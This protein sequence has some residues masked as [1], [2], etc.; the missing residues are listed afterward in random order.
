V[1]LSQLEVDCLDL[2]GD[3]QILITGPFFPA[4]DP[5]SVR[6]ACAVPP[7][8]VIDSAARLVAVDRSLDQFLHGSLT[9]G[10]PS[11]ILLTHFAGSE[12]FRDKLAAIVTGVV[13]LPARVVVTGILFP[14]SYGSVAIVIDVPE[15]WNPPHR[16]SLLAGFGPQGRDSVAQAI[17]DALLPAVA[18]VADR[19]CPEATGETVLPYFNLTYVATTTH[20]LPGR[21][22][23]PDELRY[24][25]YPRSAA[26][27]A[28]DS[29]WA[30][31]FFVAGYAFSMLVSAQPRATLEQLE[32]LLMQL[33]VVYARMDRTASAADRL[34]RSAT[35]DEDIDWLVALE[36]RLRADYQ[37]LVR[38]TFSYD[39]HVLKM[40]DSLLFAWETDK[41]R[42]RN[43]T[44]LDLARQTVER[45][46]AQDQARRV[47]R[48]NVV[49][50]VLTIVSL[51]ASIDAAFDLWAR[52]F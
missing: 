4:T 15:G 27:I 11:M 17:Y 34:I 35:R 6:P 10:N 31:E 13:G 50:A 5:L 16:R 38:P 33:D 12:A 41:V 46:F 48:V 44:L 18:E 40:R 20:P 23:L 2:V 43:E 30:E 28:S 1:D 51:V 47:G 52:L 3:A 29:T 26:P 7:D 36:R 8:G 37:A 39:Y 32:H 19:C 25:I 21:V 45:K 42:E 22:T 14:D 49:L 9:F 24:L